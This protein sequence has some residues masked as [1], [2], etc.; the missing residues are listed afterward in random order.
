M[1]HVLEKK[2]AGDQPNVE[3]MP[4]LQI[5]W[6]VAFVRGEQSPAES[7]LCAA[8]KQGPAQERRALGSA[9]QELCGAMA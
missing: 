7:G 1:L 2:N 4:L 3:E 8:C 9:S 5:F 6:D